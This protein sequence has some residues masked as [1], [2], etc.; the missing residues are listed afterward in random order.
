MAEKQKRA[1]GRGEGSI[2]QR[3]DGTWRA[4]ISLGT[5]PEGKRRRKDIYGKTKQE[6]QKKLRSA[7]SANDAGKLPTPN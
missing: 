4:A 3:P 7:R 1:Q 5:S 6:V 2:Q